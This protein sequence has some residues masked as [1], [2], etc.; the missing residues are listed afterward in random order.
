MK[1]LGVPVVIGGDNLP[2]TVETGLSEMPNIGE[3]SDPPV[4]ASL[5]W[6]P[7]EKVSLLNAMF[8]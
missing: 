3:A 2:S 5:I 6:L 4:P 7:R 8:L 1:N